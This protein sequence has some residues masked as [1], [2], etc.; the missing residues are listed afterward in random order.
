[1]EEPA[2]DPRRSLGPIPSEW[3]EM[4][5]GFEGINDTPFLLYAGYR[6]WMREEWTNILGTGRPGNFAVTAGNFAGTANVR[7]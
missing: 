3:F 6:E 1:M 4:T 7:G 2:L 5:R